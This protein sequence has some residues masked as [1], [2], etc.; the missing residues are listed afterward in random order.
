MLI[1]DIETINEE[2]R[3]ITRTKY[4]EFADEVNRLLAEYENED[5][6]N[7][8]R[9]L[10]EIAKIIGLKKGNNKWIK[11]DEEKSKIDSDGETLKVDWDIG[12]GIKGLSLDKTSIEEVPISLLLAYEYCLGVER[13]TDKKVQFDYLYLF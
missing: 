3:E 12:I 10:E 9:R 13:I 5:V 7:G 6:R 8:T 1:I 11:S 2:V 4:Q